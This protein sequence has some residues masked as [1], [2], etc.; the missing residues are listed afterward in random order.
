[1][2]IEEKIVNELKQIIADLYDMQPQEGLVMIEIPKES[3]NG[4]YSTNIAMRLTKVLKRRPQEIAAQIKEELLKRLSIIDSIDIAGPGFINFW[5]KK[6]AMANIINTV[7]DKNEDYGS[8]DAG[9]VTRVL[10][11]YVSANP[12]GPLHG[13]HA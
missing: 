12:T 9:K 11:E 8:S 5:L 10:E 2:N 3:S 1:M 6:D 13:G 7:I 4:D